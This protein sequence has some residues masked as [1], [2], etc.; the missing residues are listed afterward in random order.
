MTSALPWKVG[1]ELELLAPVGRSRESLA[2]EIARSCD[3]RVKRIFYSQAEFALLDDSTGFENLTLGFAVENEAGEVLVKC[4]DDLTLVDDLDASQ[5]PFA[6]W[7]RI[8]SDDQRFLSLIEMHCDAKADQ[9]TVLEPLARLF[10]VDQEIVNGGPLTRVS[11]QRGTSVAMAVSLPGERHRPCE[12]ITAP[13]TSNREELVRHYLTLAESLSFSV[14]VEAA[15]HIHFDGERLKSAVVMKTLIKIFGHYRSDLKRLVGTNPNCRRLGNWPRGIYRLASNADFPALDWDEAVKKLREAKPVKFCDF[16]IV[17]LLSENAE[18][19]TFEVRIIPGS[20]DADFI[21]KSVRLF[22]ALLKTCVTQ[23]IDVGH[24]FPDLM[25]FIAEV[26]L[27]N[28]DLEYW[29]SIW[30]AKAKLGN[31]GFL[32]ALKKLKE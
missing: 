17:N 10:G 8:L 14:P 32:K 28:E 25:D 4:V 13:M 16:N 26:D 30:E 1:L 29:R 18:K 6:G 7:Y 3:G 9:L 21:L 11:D 19:N 5:E 31:F 20:M 27:S 12:L 22:E 24:R 2:N 15:I 23:Q